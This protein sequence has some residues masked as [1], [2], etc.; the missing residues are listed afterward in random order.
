MTVRIFILIPVKCGELKI[1]FH[2]P[3]YGEDPYSNYLH[4]QNISI[5]VYRSRIFKK[6]TGYKSNGNIDYINK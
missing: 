3:H 1:L 5:K 6:T 2:S 4:S